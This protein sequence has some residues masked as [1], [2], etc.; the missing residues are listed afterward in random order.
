MR[1]NPKQARRHGIRPII[2]HVMRT[3]AYMIRFARRMCV[4]LARNNFRLDWLYH[5]MVTLEAPTPA[6]SRTA[7]L[8]AA[9]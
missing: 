9:A 4:R 3:A 5:A 7:S 1:G 6:R 8:Q 2:R